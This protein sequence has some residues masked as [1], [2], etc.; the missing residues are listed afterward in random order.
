[1]HQHSVCRPHSMHLQQ[2][3]NAGDA[4][5]L[6]G[7]WLLTSVLLALDAS[8]RYMRRPSASHKVVAWLDQSAAISIA[9]P[10]AD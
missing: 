9:V 3:F 1:M 8:G 6:R 2:A 5:L 7:L 4:A 10:A